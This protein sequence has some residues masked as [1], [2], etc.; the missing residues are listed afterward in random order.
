MQFIFVLFFVGIINKGDSALTESNIKKKQKK[1]IRTLSVCGVSWSWKCSDMIFTLC[2]CALVNT[3]CS[4]PALAKSSSPMCFCVC[5]FFTLRCP[6]AMATHPTHIGFTT[7]NRPLSLCDKHRRRCRE[8]R[9]RPGAHSCTM[10][11]SVTLRLPLA[12]L[13][14]SHTHTHTSWV[15]AVR[16][17]KMEV[18]QD[19]FISK[20]HQSTSNDSIAESHKSPFQQEQFPRGHWQLLSAN[21]LWACG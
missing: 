7:G 3:F 18:G 4:F 17:S 20:I 19:G 13:P 12:V 5:A 6:L 8:G 9:W 14:H 15:S 2:K 16:T 1:K 11:L 10:N 21:H